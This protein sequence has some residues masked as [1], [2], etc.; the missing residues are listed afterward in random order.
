MAGEIRDF[1][2]QID[3]VA[4]DDLNTRLANTRFPEKETVDDWDPIRVIEVR[5]DRDL[6]SDIEQ[7]TECE[8]KQRDT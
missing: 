3:Q 4:L 5:I 6:R 7:E 8:R 1:D 2:I